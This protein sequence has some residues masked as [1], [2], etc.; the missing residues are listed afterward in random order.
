MRNIAF[1]V[2]E[3]EGYEKVG[4]RSMAVRGGEEADGETAR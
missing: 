4:R 3:L 2:I 1:G